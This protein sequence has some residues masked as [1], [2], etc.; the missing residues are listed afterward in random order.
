M[1]LPSAIVTLQE[2][3]QENLEDIL[4][5]KVTD[6]QEEFVASN[7]WSLAQAHFYPEVAWFRA[8]YA[9]ETPVGFVMLED[10]PVK[11][12]YFLW[13]FMIDARFQK[14]GFGRRA[15]ELLIEHVKTRP[16]AK[17]LLTS[18]VPGEG[19]PGKFYQKQ[20]FAYTGEKEDDEA[21]MMKREL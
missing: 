5:L 1:V 10:D 18:C 2:I 14:C 21:L 19:S 20:G 7:A 15:L 6:E 3:T 4:A 11:A 13:R 12:S 8:I 16:G 9:D 17:V